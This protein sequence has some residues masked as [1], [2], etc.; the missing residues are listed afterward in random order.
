M[1][2]R[3]KVLIVESSGANDFYSEELDG[4]LTHQLTKLLGIHAGLVYGLNHTHFKKAIA[5]AA[6]QQCNVLHISCHGRKK[7]ITLTD[8]TGIDWPEF[9]QMF[10]NNRYS[11]KALVMSSCWGAADELA[12]EFEKARFKPDIIFGSTDPRYYNEYAIAWT[13]LYNSFSE[14]GVHRDVVQRALRA[15]C[16]TA[17][18]NFRY[19][20][21]HDKKK[22]YV[23]YPGD[24]NTKWSRRGS[25]R[26]AVLELRPMRI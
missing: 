7:G 3:V 9:V 5:S 14:E 21:W 18:A 17:H 6:K 13:L 16:A 20:R 12:D 23:Q 24:A 22:E 11:P 4:P 25:S 10:T 15:I 19:L 26:E 2:E 1:P 8:K